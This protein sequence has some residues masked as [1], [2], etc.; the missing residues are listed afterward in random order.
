[1]LSFGLSTMLRKYLILAIVSFFLNVRV[2]NVE[3][4][5]H[6][7]EI[8]YYWYWLAK[9]LKQIDKVLTIII[10]IVTDKQSHFYCYIYVSISL[11]KAH[12]TNCL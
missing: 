5:Q 6:V 4:L 7:I 1:M 10:T 12:S 9:L 2:R 3:F 11:E 8:N